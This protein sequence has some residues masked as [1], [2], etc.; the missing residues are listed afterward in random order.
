MRHCSYCECCIFIEQIAYKHQPNDMTQ[1]VNT[2]AC[3][4]YSLGNF[5]A[6]FNSSFRIE[7]PKPMKQRSVVFLSES[8]L[9]SFGMYLLK[10]HIQSNVYY[11]VDATGSPL[12]FTFA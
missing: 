5:V 3:F 10:L 7:L 8:L 11:G 12:F 9:I 6:S 1:I 4:V 2:I